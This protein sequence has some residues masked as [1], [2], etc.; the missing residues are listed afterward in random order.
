[1]NNVLLEE[2][3]WCEIQEAK[4]K[5]FDTVLIMTASIEQHGPYLTENTDA[6]FG[7]AIA[8]D[9]ARRLGKTLVA[10]II[11][12]G[13]SAHHMNFCGSITL[14][15]ETFRYL[16]EDHVCSYIRHGFQKIIVSSSHGGNHKAVKEIVLDLSEK[17]P[18]IKFATGIDSVKFR[19]V[20][21]CMEKEENLPLGACGG[22]AC[23]WETSTM[24][25]LAPE[26]VR[27]D[28][29]VAGFTDIENEKNFMRI[30]EEYGIQALS[31]VGVL[32]DARQA[33]DAYGKK[34]FEMRQEIIA[35]LIR[36]ELGLA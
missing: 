13:L 27:K 7:Q 16:I 36:K 31:D 22:H 1:M 32:G 21:E 11:R 33:C 34:Y 19:Q 8:E 20:R 6:V 14:R 9:L 26:S 3:T 2:M 35:D 30:M 18:E 17:Y 12:P 4:E 24:M 15:P 29:I 25:Y 23:C 28:K 10:P 5:G